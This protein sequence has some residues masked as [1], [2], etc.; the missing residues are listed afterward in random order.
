MNTTIKSMLIAAAALT[1]VSSFA[2]DKATLDLLVKKGLITA[3]ERAKTLDESAQARAAS[4]VGRVFP[5]EDATKRLTIAGYFQAAYQ[6]FN[7]KQDGLATDMPNQSQ[8]LMRRLYVEILADIGEGISGNIVLDTSGNTTSSS[9][10]WLDRAIVSHSSN[11]GTFDVGYKKVTWGYEESTLSSLFKASSS[12]LYTVERGITNRY[13]NEAEN[14]NSA[15]SDGRRLG[16]GAHHTGIHYSSVINPQGFE[17]GASVVDSAQG[18]V[19]EGNGSNDLGYFANV[20]WNNKVSDNE[21][22]A[23][24]VNYGKTKY[25]ASTATTTYATT[26]TGAPLVYTTTATTSTPASTLATMEGYN[27]FVQAQYFNWTVYGEYLST[28]VTSSKDAAVNLDDQDRKPTGY[29][30]TVVYKINDNW[31]GVARYTS[32]DTNDRGIKISDGE[33]GF[34]TKTNV[35][36]PA[37][38]GNSDAAWNKAD[39]IYLGLNYYFTIPVAGAAAV[40]GPNAKIQFGLERANFNG[41][42]TAA[43]TV[44]NTN[45]HDASKAYV[46]ALRVQAQVAF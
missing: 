26:A 14:G 29:N 20:V 33:R 31:E 42:I 7:Y 44:T 10:S 27:P 15:R 6:S 12:K 9:T 2:Q 18:R 19:T 16:F 45:S 37:A 8:F 38:A 46:D 22:Y 5:K 23:I 21:K 25:F 36:S 28:K 40:N 3:E 1:A 35:A 34:S 11:L 30:A 39:A 43:T 17:Y 41:K 24:G 32:L 4:G 13:W